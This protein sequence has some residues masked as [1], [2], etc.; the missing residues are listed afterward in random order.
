[1]NDRTSGVQSATKQPPPPL[2]PPQ[3]GAAAQGAVQLRIKT[4]QSSG[5]R[6]SQSKS[7]VLQEPVLLQKPV[8]RHEGAPLCRGRHS[9]LIHVPVSPDL[10]TSEESVAA[11][12]P[13]SRNRRRCWGTAG[14][15]TCSS[16]LNQNQLEPDQN[17]IRTIYLTV[18]VPRYDQ[19]QK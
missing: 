17:Q 6:L 15:S 12:R 13:R 10:S 2:L 4:S 19:T 5:D 18:F 14:E 8:R 9:V 7:M 3:R 1:M 16:K 11:R